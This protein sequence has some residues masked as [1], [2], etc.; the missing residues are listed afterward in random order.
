MVSRYALV[1][2]NGIVE[3]I[4]LWDGKSSWEPPKNVV[5]RQISNDSVIGI[6]DRIDSV[7]RVINTT[8][9]DVHAETEES[10][11]SKLDAVLRLLVDRDII[12]A[13]DLDKSSI[14]VKGIT[15]SVN[16]QPIKRT[17]T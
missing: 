14:Q 5:L 4:V 8:I 16:E 1:N 7:G 12:T 13:D 10:P 9:P 2:A 17:K 6:G 3:N 11:S 15:V